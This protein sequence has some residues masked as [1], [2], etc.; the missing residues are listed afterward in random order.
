MLEGL[1]MTRT[2]HARSFASTSVSRRNIPTALAGFCGMALCTL[3]SGTLS[4]GG[5]GSQAPAHAPRGVLPAPP[6]YVLVDIG[7]LPGG[8]AT[9]A[10]AINNLGQVVGRVQKTWPD[11]SQAFIWDPTTGVMQSINKDPGDTV[12]PNA[13]NDSSVVV[14]SRLPA[15]A[16]QGEWIGYIWDPVNGGQDLGV[17]PSDFEA[18]YGLDVNNAGQV[19]GKSYY[20][21]PVYPLIAYYQPVV[22][23][24]PNQQANSIAFLSAEA[25]LIDDSGMIIGRKLFDYCNGSGLLLLD[26]MGGYTDLSPMMGGKS[27]IPEDLNENGLVVGW[28][29]GSQYYLTDAFSLDLSTGIYTELGYLPGDIGS[30][31]RGTNDLGQVVGNSTGPT[32]TLVSRAFLYDQGVLYDLADLVVNGAGWTLDVAEDVNDA[33]EIVGVGTYQGVTR[34]FVLRPR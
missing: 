4:V 14:G 21:D 24:V 1:S 29:P 18:S 10:R 22:F 30:I 19:V 17:I 15:G 7:T 16:G 23:D 6:S 2:H 13:I 28:I 31:A 25:S 32:P 26:G 20:T 27:G 12:V 33:G 9:R 8:I 5:G 3:G 34:S 11:P